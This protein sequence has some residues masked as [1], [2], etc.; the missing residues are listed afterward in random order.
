MAWYIE[1]SIACKY[2]QVVITVSC[3]TSYFCFI[4]GVHWHAATRLPPDH[5]R[6]TAAARGSWPT[7][8]ACLATTVG[9]CSLCPECGRKVKHNH[10]TGTV[11]VQRCLLY[12]HCGSKC[13]GWCK[14][15][16]RVPF[17]CLFVSF[18]GRSG[19]SFSLEYLSLARV[20]MFHYIN[21][22]NMRVTEF[23]LSD[24]CIYSIW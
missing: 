21:P 7:G 16:L 13:C 24:N 22:N 8:C 2:M 4:Q 3:F 1:G 18:L 6:F 23:I 10:S 20:I 14:W 5:R 17:L 9:W 12:W 15:H 19:M 11:V